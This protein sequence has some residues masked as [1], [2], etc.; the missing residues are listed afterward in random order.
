MTIV[1]P[2]AHM[3]PVKPDLAIRRDR[4]QNGIPLLSRSIK[5]DELVSQR[6]HGPSQAR[7]DPPPGPAPEWPPLVGHVTG[8]AVEHVTDPDVKHATGPAVEHVTGP[9]VEHLT[10]PTAEGTE[11]HRRADRWPAEPALSFK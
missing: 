2:N 10:R 9:A 4:L 6:Q 3:G 8:P 7:F 11:G 5:N 1:G